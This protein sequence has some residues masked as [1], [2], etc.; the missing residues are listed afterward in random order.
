MKDLRVIFM[1]TP[2][3]SVPILASLIVNTNVILVVT[4]IDQKVGRNQELSFSPV[5][6]LA[7][8]N[9]IPL[10]QPEK[11]KTDYQMI[12]DLNPDII[13]TCAYGQIIPKEVL[14]CPK[15]G[16]INVHASLL[17]KYRGGA[18][19][20]H[21][22]INGESKTGI[23]I[24][25]MNEGMDTGDIIAKEELPILET[26]N[27]G[28]LFDKLSLLGESLLIKT[29]PS[30]INSSCKKEKQDDNLATY[31]PTL[32]RADELLSFSYTTKEV[33]DK[34]RGLNPW[35]LAYIILNGEETKILECEKSYE[36]FNKKP[37]E[38]TRILKDKLGIKTLD[39]EILITKIKP[40]GKKEMLVKDYLNG[41]KDKEKIEV[42]N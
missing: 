16:C 9:N 28:T 32:K 25:Y 34:V 7:L 38:I 24:M 40:Y 8:E 1:G 21:A 15:Y 12:L 11:I 31:A 2:D 41:L 37:G 27:V 13:I 18:P 36:E 29:L 17:P 10:F 19:I 6:K 35:P 4:K 42:G 22:I 3:F 26:D 39:G 5:K 14:N 33:F 30:I 23:T 20:H